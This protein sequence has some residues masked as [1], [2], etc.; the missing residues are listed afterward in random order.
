M[1]EDVEVKDETVQQE[2][3]I[4]DFILKRADTV[5]EVWQVSNALLR[6]S[7]MIEDKGIKLFVR[8]GAK[9]L[10]KNMITDMFEELLLEEKQRKEEHKRLLAKQEEERPPKPRKVKRGR[11]VKNIEER[12]EERIVIGGDKFSD[13]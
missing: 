11:R 3:M 9:I 6:M 8:K 13:A 2:K 7:Q 1:A 10:I 5:M 4:A 12:D